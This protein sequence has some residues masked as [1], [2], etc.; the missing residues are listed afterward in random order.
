MDFIGHGVI[1]RWSMTM[2]NYILLSVIGLGLLIKGS[3]IVK[4]ARVNRTE[5]LKG[6]QSY[7]G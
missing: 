2:I 5:W 6:K 4:K 3:L 1:K 7:D